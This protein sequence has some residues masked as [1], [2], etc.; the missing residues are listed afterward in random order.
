M[1]RLE[2]LEPLKEFFASRAASVVKDIFH[3]PIT[4]RSVVRL[5]AKRFFLFSLIITFLLSVASAG[6]AAESR[7]GE[8]DKTLTAAETEGE[9]T[10]YVVDYPRLTVSQFQ[11]A[12]SKIRLN[13]VDGPSGPALTSRLMAER[14]AGK[15]QADLY[16]A[17]QGTHVRFCIRQ[18]R[19]H[20]CLRLLFCRR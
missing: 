19:W 13:Q 11:K 14:R 20:P 9:V 5:S 7:P 1:E 10:V 18:K 8:W 17:G 12:F 15:Y 2:R 16:I 6:R 3:T 4:E